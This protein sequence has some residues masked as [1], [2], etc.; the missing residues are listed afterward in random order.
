MRRRK[1]IR[2]G[3]EDINITPVM[4][5]VFLI[6]IYFFVV[7]S[8][9]FKN[10]IYKIKLPIASESP[11][12][13]GK[14]KY[15]S[16][17]FISNNEILIDSNDKKVFTIKLHELDKYLSNKDEVLLSID[18]NTEYKNVIEIIDKLKSIGITKINLN[19]MS[20]GQKLW[21]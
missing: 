8:N 19:S 5:V 1:K 18:K 13:I 15:K 11:A 4:D 14:D 16:V 12:K 9:G 7:G 6:L 3:L 21:L 20:E 17:T 2:D 10:Q